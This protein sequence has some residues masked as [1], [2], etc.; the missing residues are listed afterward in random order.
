MSQQ[1]EFLKPLLAIVI[2]VLILEAIIF[3][4]ILYTKS[5]SSKTHIKSPKAT[6]GTA[7]EGQ[8]IREWKLAHPSK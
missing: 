5:L 2:A 7:P 4:F 1:K 6:F 8:S 3:G